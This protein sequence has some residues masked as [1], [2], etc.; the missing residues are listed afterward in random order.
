MPQFIL[1]G[2][3]VAGGAYA[4]KALKREMT[5]VDREMTSVRERPTD[6][7]E[8]DPATGRYTPKKR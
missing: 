6:T 8:L 1:L 7:L 4:W 2:V 5:R 3:I